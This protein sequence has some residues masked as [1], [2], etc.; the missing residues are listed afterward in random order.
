MLRNDGRLSY[1]ASVPDELL[2]TSSAQ[3]ASA[4]SGPS[5]MSQRA[6]RRRPGA[7]RRRREEP[8][9]QRRT[10]F[11]SA[12]VTGLHNRGADTMRTMRR[13]QIADRRRRTPPEWPRP[14]SCGWLG[15]DGDLVV[16]HDEEEPPY[17]RPACSKGLL[18]GHSRPERRDHAAHAGLDV[19]WQLGRK[20]VHL[21]TEA[22]RSSRD[23][24]EVVR[25]RRP[26]DRHRR[27][28]DG[29]SRAGRRRA[30]PPRPLPDATT[31]GACAR[32]C[33]A[34]T[35]RRRR[36]RAHRLRGRLRGARHGPRLRTS[37]TPSPTRWPAR[38]ASI[39]GRMVAEEMHRRTASG[40]AAAGAWRA[41]TAP[42][43]AGR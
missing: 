27:L 39:V 25:L 7:R 4:P 24:D 30:R 16:L 34:P 1:R 26:G 37:S 32:T 41:S 2:T 31:P 12:T 10:T 33:A 28:R 17:D 14:R 8:R 13:E 21:D 20:A 5:R 15:F 40:C 3:P 23:T 18:S 9:D 43:A 35:G 38:S 29:P 42:V 22:P 6:D 11:A 36:R 19:H